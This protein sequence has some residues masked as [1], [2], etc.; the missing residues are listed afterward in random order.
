MYWAS[1]DGD[2]ADWHI[3]VVLR[4][5]RPNRR[6]GFTHDA[7]LDGS[8]GIRGFK[9]DAASHDEGI[10]FPIRACSGDAQ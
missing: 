8:D 4:V 7:R 2:E 6:D 9:L 3:G 10:W 1:V 5:L